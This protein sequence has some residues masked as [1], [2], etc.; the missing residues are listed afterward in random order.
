ML[1]PNV[2]GKQYK[3]KINPIHGLPDE[4]TVE[5][6]IDL[7]NNEVIFHY[8]EEDTTSPN[9]YNYCLYQLLSDYDLHPQTLSYYEQ[10]K[11]LLNFRI[12]DFK[13]AL[14]DDDDRVV[15]YHNKLQEIFNGY[16]NIYLGI[17]PY[18]SHNK[19]TYGLS[20]RALELRPLPQEV[21]DYIRKIYAMGKAQGV[22]LTALEEWAKEEGGSG[23]GSGK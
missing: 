17:N 9:Y 11:D 1:R 7:E 2:W 19:G 23:S 10:V 12:D 21:I 16:N 15:W 22:T 20:K 18:V 6:A 4:I 14:Y 13:V 5:D 3:H 8:L